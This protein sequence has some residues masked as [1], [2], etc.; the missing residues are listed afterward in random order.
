LLCLILAGIFAAVH[1]KYG[2][3]RRHTRTRCR[4]AAFFQVM[5]A[6]LTFVLTTVCWLL[7]CWTY[8]CMR[9]GTATSISIVLYV[10]G[11]ICAFLLGLLLLCK[12]GQL[13][14]SRINNQKRSG[15]ESVE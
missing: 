14:C 3:Y 4:K 5:H 12:A 11:C 8:V 7:I 10:V 6:V 9:A 2:P 13:L 15:N 1:M